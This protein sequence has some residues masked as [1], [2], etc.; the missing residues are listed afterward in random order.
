MNKDCPHQDSVMFWNVVERRSN[1]EFDTAVTCEDCGAK[2]VITEVDGEDEDS[3]SVYL[4]ERWDDVQQLTKQE[5][6]MASVNVTWSTEDVL[7][8]AP[9]LS[10][11]QANAVL[12]LAGV[13]EHNAEV[14][15]N[16][17]VL[18][19]WATTVQEDSELVE[20]TLENYSDCLHWEAA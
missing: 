3:D 2:G 16:W 15:V 10:Q 11:K 14:G 12:L 19:D 5:G 1:G 6:Y 8:V 4:S 20:R 9:E 17:G 13:A 18:R 7:Q